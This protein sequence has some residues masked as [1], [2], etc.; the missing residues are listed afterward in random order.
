MRFFESRTA[1]QKEIRRSKAERR[2]TWYHRILGHLELGRLTFL[3]LCSVLTALLV[4]IGPDP[5]GLRV[6]QTVPR[7]ITARVA[8]Q[9]ADEARTQVERMRARDN[10]EVYYTLETSLVQDLRGRLSNALRLARELAADPEKLA[11]QAADI[12]I[13]FDSAGLEEIARLAALPESNLYQQAVERAI[14]ILRRQPLVEP[15]D[16]ANRRTATRAVLVDPELGTEQPTPAERLLYTHNRENV[17]AVVHV[18][19]EAFPA[20]LRETIRASLTRMF[21]TTTEGVSKSLF[22]YDA[23]RSAK[24]AEDAERSVPPQ[25]IP[26]A[27]GDRL[28]QAGPISA[29]ELKLLE[30]EH[31]QYQAQCESVPVLERAARLARFARAAIAFLLVFGVAGF[32]T[33]AYHEALPSARR[34]FVTAGVL[35][36]V[37]VLGR[38]AYVHAPYVH[39]A[40]GGQAL[41]AGLLALTSRRGPAYAGAGLLAVLLTL[42]TA[43]GSAFLA[44]LLAI[45]LILFYGLHTVRNRGRI[46]AVGALAALGGGLAA[47]L[48]G[49]LDGQTWRFVFWNQTLWAMLTT[50]AAAFLI[51]GLLPGIERLFAVTTSMTL[52]EWCDPNKPLLRMLAAESPGTYNHSL[53]VGTL[54]NAAAEAIGANALLARC[55]AYYHDIGKTNKPEYFVENQAVGMGSR[56]D[57]LS[58]AMSHLIIIGHVKDGLAMAREYALPTALHAF[59]PEHHGT[60]LV[61]YFY[62][63]A[64]RARRPD[65]PEVSDEQFRYPGPKPQSRETAIVML[66]DGVEGA[67]RA[68]TEPTPNRIE[69]TVARIVDKRLMDGQL[70]ECDLTFRELATIRQSLVKSLCS[71]YHARITYPSE[72]EEPARSAS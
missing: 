41:A 42:A 49:A 36:L 19:A 23:A 6:G 54:A 69:D 68:M 47:Q 37:F 26:I 21:E 12:Q 70:D 27:V 31:E 22:V 29:E 50:L 39:L 15:L 34:R 65:D 72:T 45:S 52:L 1:R 30:H 25:F 60:C 24:A 8:F 16:L 13:L 61:E 18:A 14:Q 43:Q 57:R 51:E 3:V 71:I 58:P 44:M 5:L 9:L 38:L 28:A 4:N 64:T 17:T 2:H 7:A 48:A 55:G 11:A 63:A 62:H 20:P 35:L 66:C 33:S 67:V 56:H 59:I 53:L 32:L 46:I 40:A 10:A